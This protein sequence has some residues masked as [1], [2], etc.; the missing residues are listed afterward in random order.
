MSNTIQNTSNGQVYKG[1]S[2]VDPYQ[3][4]KENV[5]KTFWD[6]A[7]ESFG[8]RSSYQKQIQDLDLQ[9][10]LRQ[11]QLNMLEDEAKYNS[12]AEKAQRMREAGMNPD[13]QGIGEA[14]E[15][16]EYN[17]P[18][19]TPSAFNY[20]DS[21]AQIASAFK[22]CIDLGL[23]LYTG[24]VNVNGLMIDNSI[25]SAQRIKS[26]TDTA[27]DVVDNSLM[28]PGIEVLEKDP[29][30]GNKVW[31][32]LSGKNLDTDGLV[33]KF[34]KDGVRYSVPTFMIPDIEFVNKRDQRVFDKVLSQYK[35][36]IFADSKKYNEYY[37]YLQNRKNSALSSSS[38]FN[39][40]SYSQLE[41][42]FRP[43]S[44]LMFDVDKLNL[45]YNEIAVSNAKKYEEAY[46]AEGGPE[47]AAKNDVQA[48]LSS[49]QLNEYNKSVNEAWNTA[50]KSIES[51]SKDHPIIGMIGIVLLNFLR[52][53][54]PMPKID[55]SKHNQFVTNQNDNRIFNDTTTDKVVN[56]NN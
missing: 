17:E 23:G 6:Q 15:S 51:Y 27:R 44:K 33:K 26:I 47:G 19:Q 40:P 46:K 3:A 25:K 54:M 49:E 31:R 42:V 52:S 2:S 14:S 16:G 11:D 38:P 56:I 20:E 53:Q 35:R 55:L 24:F 22:T 18:E 48:N 10:N 5:K 30:S 36:S 1:A 12:E 41:E 7:L 4:Q 28:A 8:F 43:I 37:N 21:G 45:Q 34:G 39:S 29:E 32:M 13:L 9:S 50:Q